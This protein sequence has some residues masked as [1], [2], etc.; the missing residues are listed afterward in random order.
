[1]TIADLQ[2]YTPLLKWLGIISFVTFITSILLI[3]WLVR[4]LPP[5][6]FIHGRKLPV[7]TRLPPTVSLILAL[8]RNV[9][10]VLLILAGF[11]MLFLPG[12]GILTMLLGISLLN[13]PGKHALIEKLIERPSVHQGLN[14]LRTK[15]KRPP[16]IWRREV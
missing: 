8:L 13:F 16:F 14:W 3:P 9:L 4:L 10:G 7:S 11:A 2:Q 6:Y 12:Q 1:M 5:D 15:T